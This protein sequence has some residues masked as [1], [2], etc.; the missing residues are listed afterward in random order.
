MHMNIFFQN[1]NILCIFW[2]T[3]TLYVLIPDVFTKFTLVASTNLF[4]TSIDP[5]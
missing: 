5:P 3:G 4:Y 1:L 2:S